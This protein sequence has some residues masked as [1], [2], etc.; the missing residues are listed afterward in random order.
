MT[1]EELA[2]TGLPLVEEGMQG[3][4]IA[5]PSEE[6]S[7]VDGS[8]N[9]E[10]GEIGSEGENIEDVDAD[11]KDLFVVK[12]SKPLPPSFVFGESKVTANLIREY[13]AAGFFPVGSG[14]APLDEEI[15]TLEADEIVVFR[16]LFTRGLRFPCDP[17]LSA[18]LDKFSVKIHH[19]SP[20][21]F[22]ELSKFFGS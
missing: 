19:L 14:R 1:T 6:N 16:D 12:R 4:E 9:H 13:E 20:S 18:I 10:E 11:L 8:T 2:T 3:T 21:S 15:L 22:L 17:L 7:A 5:Q